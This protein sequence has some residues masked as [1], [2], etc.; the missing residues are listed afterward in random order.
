[1]EFLGLCSAFFRR[2][3]MMVGMNVVPFSS[4][5]AWVLRLCGVRVGS[6][7]YIG[8]NVICDTNYASLITIGD[9]VTISHNTSIFAHTATPV[10]S[11][12]SWIY[13]DVRAVSIKNGAWIGAH[14]I[15]L[16]GVTIG[17]NC[18]IGAG[19]VVTKSTD[20]CSVYAGNPCRK[21]KVLPS[22]SNAD[23]S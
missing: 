15:L 9:K 21:I 1:V 6:D 5:R 20:A 10:K 2:Y 16:P 3:L 13:H 7:C 19:S 17:E 4:V 23:C 18:M 14:C 11:H 8:F 12:L 22:P